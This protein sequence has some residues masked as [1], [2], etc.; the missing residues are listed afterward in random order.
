MTTKTDE[1]ERAD[2]LPCPFCGESKSLIVQHCEGTIIHPAYRIYCGNCGA[3]SG[4][5]DRVD[6]A[7]YWN[8]RA[9]LQSQDGEDAQRYRALVDSGLFVPA[10]LSG[11]SIWGLHMSGT[12]ATKAELDEAIDHARRIEGGGK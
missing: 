6:P 11:S 8:S 5:A 2:L 4:Y 3:S 10:T 1:Q 9:A 7:K 12:K